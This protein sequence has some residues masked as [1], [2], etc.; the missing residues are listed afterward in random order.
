MLL[1]F[2]A[3]TIDGLRLSGARGDGTM[4]GTM[5]ANADGITK[6]IVG[7]LGAFF[8]G[9]VKLLNGEVDG[10]DIGIMLGGE[11]SLV[12]GDYVHVLSVGIDA[13]PGVD[14]NLGGAT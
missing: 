12:R 11:G 4:D 6:G 13:P 8:G 5:T 1:A 9:A 3:I 2:G 14:R 7:G 10:C